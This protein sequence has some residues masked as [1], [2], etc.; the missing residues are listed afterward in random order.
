M[1]KV[2]PTGNRRGL[3]LPIV[4]VA[5]AVPTT[6]ALI[7][8]PKPGTAVPSQSTAMAI[9]TSGEID[10]NFVTTAT[11]ATERS[12]QP[13]DARM[14]W[15]NGNGLLSWDAPSLVSDSEFIDRTTT[16][17][18]YQRPHAVRVTD[19]RVAVSVTYDLNTVGVWAQTEA[20]KWGTMA[21][22]ENTGDDTVSCLVQL[23]SG[24]LVC[25]YTYAVSTTR[26]QVRMATS[27]DG[28][29]TWAVGSRDCLSSPLSKTSSAYPRIRAVYLDGML[30]VLL[31]EQDTTDTIYQYVSADDGATLSLVETFSTANRA[32]PDM[33]VRLGKIIVA[34]IEYDSTLTSST[35]VPRIRRLS[36]AAQPLS[37][38]TAVEAQ[39][40]ATGNVM[41]WGTFGGG[42]FSASECALLA[43]DDGDLWL[44]G[45]DFDATSA[46]EV[47]MR[48]SSDGGDTWSQNGASGL[49][50][51][52][53][54]VLWYGN[55]TSTY[56]R[57]LAVT[58]ERGRAVMVHRF[59][60]NPGTA[61]DSLCVLYLGGWSN[62]G[63]PEDTTAERR[64]GQIGWEH[65]YLPFDLPSDIGGLW[66]RTVAGAGADTLTSTG[67]QL[68]TAAGTDDIYYSRTVTLT[69]PIADGILRE[70]EI[71]P[72]SGTYFQDTRISD[73]T[74]DFDVRVS[75]T[76]TSIVVRDRNA[77]ADVI[78]LTG[79]S[80]SNGVVVRVALDKPSG[81]WGANSGRV[82]IWYR[83]R[84][85]AYS[86]AGPT[87]T[88]TWVSGGAATGL[89]FGAAT[90]ARLR[91]GITQNVADVTVRRDSYTEG[92]YTSG[93]LAGSA[94]GTTRGRVISGPSSPIHLADGLRI[95]ATSGP[96][97][98]GD[99]WT[100][101]PAWDYAPANVSPTLA[102]SPRRGF[103]TQLDNATV[104]LVWTG[105]DIGWR[106]GDLLGIWLSG[107]NFPTATLYRD[108]SAVNKVADLSLIAKAGLG[109]TRS[110]GQIAPAAGA[111]LPFHV[112]ENALTGATVD[113][114]GGVLRK[115]ARNREGSWVN[116][117]V[118]AQPGMR[119]DL[120]SYDGADPSSGTLDL[121]MPGGLFL[122]ETMQATD[123]LM[124][125]I[126]ASNTADN[127]YR[128]GKI[129]IG[130]VRMFGK[131]YG[132]GRGLG[133]T[134]QVDLVTT[135]AGGRYG[136]V[137]APRLRTMEF[138]WGDPVDLT[139]LHTSTSAPDWITM[140]YSGAD[141][142]ASIPGTAYT[143]A[144]ELAT[145]G[146]SYPIVVLPSVKAFSAATTTAAPYADYNPFA[147]FY[148]RCVTETIR[149]DSDAGIGGQELDD[150]S[151]VVRVGRCVFE[152]ER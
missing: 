68:T 44:Y 25:L 127:D 105:V 3:L 88:R 1:P 20:G 146:A 98:N 85:S 6:S 152:E 46:R 11:V 19:G 58:P 120:E 40:D 16:A 89:T 5:D 119:L 99:T 84:A 50:T 29:T 113:L 111:A 76:S 51:G 8:G 124:L 123:T 87:S 135:Q 62:V 95:H 75:V 80:L 56:P 104:D 151:E 36:S 57:D 100:I 142:V 114:G 141:P 115:V 109:Y 110:R 150:P 78:S 136:R 17:N 43:D 34:T 92:L 13:G 140:G 32:C 60:A 138:D 38:A 131:Q 125:R 147:A 86:L 137:R 28:G 149:V 74:N 41:E 148:G 2:D 45:V 47:I 65:C 117:A 33:A 66:A 53:G 130:R 24:R 4:S 26:T 129:V 106:T 96:T 121:W 63:V 22:V 49:P 101:S 21:T 107:C 69:A 71:V 83:A 128:I 91:F 42:I 126:T 94:S 132:R 10:S 139:G 14:R 145:I 108:S 103:R 122:T 102:P 31:W 39:A 27:D 134:P 30:S 97:V 81:A 116:A 9:V 7:A 73:T 59:V 12:G 72:T 55:D 118:T 70:V 52:L 82:R 144:E 18:R 15:N 23:P 79:L 77:G 54:T 67:L 37:S 133:W 90:T 93:N 48:R 64:A 35:L 112:H 143:V 61:D